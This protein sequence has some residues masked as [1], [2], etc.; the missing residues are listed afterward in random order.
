MLYGQKVN[1][2]E[3]KYAGGWNGVVKRQLDLSI[4]QRLVL[5]NLFHK[6][7][8]FMD[9]LP[10]KTPPLVAIGGATEPEDVSLPPDVTSGY[11]SRDDVFLQSR[12][13]LLLPSGYIWSGSWFCILWTFS[14]SV[15][16]G[17]EHQQRYSK[18]LS[19]KSN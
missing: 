11:E 15:L 10:T 2:D 7:K 18:T 9:S 12:S 3:A 4:P 17:F 1:Y 13:W 8:N 16:E 19:F 5:N 14:L 6:F